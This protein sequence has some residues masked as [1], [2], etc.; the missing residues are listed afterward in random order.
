MDPGRTNLSATIHPAA[1]GVSDVPVLE[2][3]G[4]GGLDQP[5]ETIR[6]ATLCAAQARPAR[7]FGLQETRAGP[8]PS[9]LPVSPEGDHFPQAPKMRTSVLSPNPAPAPPRCHGWQ[10]IRGRGG[11]QC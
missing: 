9:S 6:S 3:E 11:R 5:G 7:S 1:A 2:D 10:R 8:N 4:S